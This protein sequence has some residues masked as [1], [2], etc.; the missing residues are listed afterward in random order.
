MKIILAVYLSHGKAVSHYKGDIEQETI[1]SR[2]PLQSVQMFEREGLSAVHFIDIDGSPAN[3]DVAKLV[4]QK[5]SLKVSYADGISSIENISSLFSGGIHYISLTQTSEPLLA[6]ALKKFGPDKIFFTIRT[7]RHVILDRPGL[8]VMD[9]GKDLT[10]QGVTHIILRDMKAEGTFHPN[11]D[12]VERLI[13]GTGAQIFAF[14]GIGSMEDLEI[15]ERTGA[16]GVIISK[17]FFERKLG[18]RECVG[19]FSIS[20]KFYT[21]Y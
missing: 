13:I 1:L 12:E 15:M 18:V 11:F 4:A 7:Q 2:D 8:E 14:G 6:E 5:T 3:R 19:R 20:P 17:A 9:Y 16:A 10:V 21:S